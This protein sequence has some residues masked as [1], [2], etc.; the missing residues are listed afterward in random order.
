MGWLRGMRVGVRL[1][2][3]F[4]LVAV[5]LALI[6]GIGV[7]IA[8]SQRATA[9]GASQSLRENE[10]VSQVKFD[11]AI[12]ALDENSVA[13]DY[14]SQSDPSGDLQSLSDDSAAFTTDSK[15][16]T[17]YPLRGA[18]LANVQAAQ[19][20]FTAYLYLSNQINT[21]F[22]AGDPTSVQ[23]ASQGVA[24]L[25]YGK[26][27][28]PLAALV[29]S[30][31]HR[32]SVVNT[33][34]ATAAGRS[35]WTVLELVATGDLRHTISTASRDEMGRLTTALNRVLTMVRDAIGAISEHSLSLIGTERELSATSA[36]MA[37][38]AEQA[39][40]HA[41]AGSAAAAEVAEVAENVDVV[42]AAARQM[43]ASIGSITE[44]VTSA[45]Q[46]ATRAVRAAKTTSQTM[47]ELGNSS[48]EIG[49]VVKVIT[50]IAEQTNLLALNATIEAAR[51][52]DQGKGFAVV[53]GEVKDLEPRK[54][55]VRVVANHVGVEWKVVY[56]TK[57]NVLLAPVQSTRRVAW[58]MFGAFVVA[59]LL[60]LLLG[61]RALLNSTRLAHARL[62]DALTGLPNRALFLQHAQ[63]A[64]DACRRHGG[65]LAALFLDLDGFKPINDTHGHTV[66][67]ALLA[68]VAERLSDSSRT[69]DVVG[70]FGGDEFL[71]LC[72]QLSSDE[73]AFDIADRLQKAI[74]EPFVIDGRSLCVSVS[75]GIATF[76][77]ARSSNE[78]IHNADLAMY[79]AKQSGKGRTE[80][81]IP[82]LATRSPH[83]EGMDSRSG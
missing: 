21:G 56:A 8:G 19:S 9:L 45:T 42:A 23:T 29:D 26:I 11:A 25:S 39:T 32:A 53:A 68:A 74:A 30:V 5:L 13:Y 55:L 35:R 18:D 60:M 12:V 6:A 70:R 65:P 22:R 46:V 52:G 61:T 58:Q 17:R 76:Q 16:L 59:I 28:K 24:A 81:F 82:N 57:T 4:G 37:S 54:C 51:A 77:H 79:R 47:T 67:D 43:S 3:G 72:R 83:P 66:G 36:E 49:E 41:R 64:I 1:A 44:N 33:A 63:H 14:A 62:H 2:S 40:G 31:N 15:A 34:Q 20:A 7:S 48:A 80:L 27:A 38:C 10:V 75:I 78:L 71:V 50:S 69:G 73:D